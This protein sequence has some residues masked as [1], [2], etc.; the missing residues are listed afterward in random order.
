MDG[1][2][3]TRTARVGP[4]RCLSPVGGR[5]CL[6][7]CPCALV[8]A[9]LLCT[10]YLSASERKV[11]PPP[12]ALAAASRKA[13][14]A[15]NPSTDSLA[16]L[17]KALKE[18]AANAEL[19]AVNSVTVAAGYAAVPVVYNVI[20]AEAARVAEA[21]VDVATARAGLVALRVLLDGATADN[22]TAA[23]NAEVRAGRAAE[24][25]SLFLA[26]SL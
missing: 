8:G 22:V 23:D 5:H 11:V 25:P 20:I 13:A 18:G 4:R 14:A 15:E 12:P 19:T 24:G 17:L 2:G 6:T 26:V 7:C 1:S 10:S 21:V 9:G 3:S 16:P